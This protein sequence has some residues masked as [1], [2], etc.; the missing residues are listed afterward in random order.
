MTMCTLLCISILGMG[1]GIG[2]VAVLKMQDENMYHSGNAG[3]NVGSWE[4]CDNGWYKGTLNGE[5]W[6]TRDKK[7]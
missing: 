5:H 6:K 2:V 4:D 1:F 3:Y 7:R